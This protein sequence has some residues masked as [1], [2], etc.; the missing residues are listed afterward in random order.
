MVFMTLNLAGIFVTQWQP[1]AENLVV[2]DKQ[3]A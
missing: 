3:G 2:E 1:T